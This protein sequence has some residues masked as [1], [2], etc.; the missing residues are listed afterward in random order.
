MNTLREA[1]RE[2]RER[3]SCYCFLHFEVLQEYVTT[4][5]QDRTFVCSNAEIR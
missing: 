5:V 4:T 3:E 1:V 2:M